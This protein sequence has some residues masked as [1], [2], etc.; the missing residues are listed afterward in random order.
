[1]RI[2]IATL[3]KNE[4]PLNCVRAL[5]HDLVMRTVIRNSDDATG[6]TQTNTPVEEAVTFPSPQDLYDRAMKTIPGF[7]RAKIR[8]WAKDNMEGPI[9][10]EITEYVKQVM[11]LLPVPVP[12]IFLNAAVNLIVPPTP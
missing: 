4:T 12:A 3:Y 1:M 9:G 5:G 11:S 7:L 2:R 8:K 10:L 6:N